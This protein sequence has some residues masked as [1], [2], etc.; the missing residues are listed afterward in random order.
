MKELW[1]D[2]ETTGTDSKQH[3]IIQLA[4][5]AVVEGDVHSK[6]WRIR[7]FATDAI[8]DAALAVNRTT[9]VEIAGYP[10]PKDVHKEVCAF[11]DRF[12]D[13]FDRTDKLTPGGYNAD[14]FD[15]PF[16]K[17]WFEKCGDRYFGSYFNYMTIDPYPV[18]RFLRY[19]RALDLSDYKLATVCQAFNVSL[20]EGAHDALADVRATRALALALKQRIHSIGR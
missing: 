5:I 20:G 11:L 14:A 7:P 3:G 2:V 8:D 6:S 18:V 17:A 9:K 16:L 19:M 10:E 13:K 12:V 15:L 1:F 4:M